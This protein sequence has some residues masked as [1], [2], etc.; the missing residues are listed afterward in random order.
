M[1]IRASNPGD[2][3]ERY[4]VGFTDDLPNI[5]NLCNWTLYPAFYQDLG[6]EKYIVTHFAQIDPV[7][8]ED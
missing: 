7:E 2:H 1:L 6:I 4:F 5:K 3:Y 8:I